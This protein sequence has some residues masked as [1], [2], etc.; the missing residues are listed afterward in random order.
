MLQT[1][2]QYLRSAAT[3]SMAT[4]ILASISW[5]MTHVISPTFQNMAL[6]K[7]R[8]LGS[9]TQAYSMIGHTTEYDEYNIRID[10]LALLW[11]EAQLCLP[12]VCL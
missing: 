8:D 12:Y 6:I 9:G 4:L 7:G 11:G 2:E 3:A 5:L 10:K 1:E